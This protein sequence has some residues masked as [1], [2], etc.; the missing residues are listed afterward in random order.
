MKYD[1]LEKEI[2]YIYDK[3]NKIAKYKLNV[4]PIK[5]SKTIIKILNKKSKRTYLETKLL[6][7]F[8]RK[9]LDV[10]QQRSI[11]LEL[12][13]QY[14]KKQKNTLIQSK[15][16]STKNNNFVNN[17]DYIEHFGVYI[18]KKKYKLNISK[19]NYA[20]IDKKSSMNYSKQ[21]LEKCHS[22]EVLKDTYED[23]EY[24]IYTD[25]WCEQHREE[26]LKNF[27]LNMK[28]FN[29]LDEKD[30]NREV[31]K[32]F[33]KYRKF[34]EIKNLDEC[35]DK[36]GVYILVLDKFKQ[37]YIGQTNNSLKKRIVAHWKKTKNFD[38]LI[39]GKVNTSI[40]SIDCFG[41]LDTTRIFV[42]YTSNQLKIE[43][44]LTDYVPNKYQLNRAPGGVIGNDTFA[45][46]DIIANGNQRNL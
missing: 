1:V 29:E 10:L 4:E 43:R 36:A 44:E 24:K 20:K 34:I 35:D 9:Q 14:I 28:Y 7:R 31:N 8:R 27:D 22:K 39:Y 46:L 2:K 16:K 37:I 3:H 32:I 33:K 6:N 40:L 26:C 17:P 15:I 5:F 41:A 13:E 19:E 21:Y 38:R 18:N 42:M 12:E 30:F 11:K 25:K 23:S 45:V